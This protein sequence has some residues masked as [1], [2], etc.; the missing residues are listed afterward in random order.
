MK[1]LGNNNSAIGIIRVSS[2][3]QSDD[4]SFRENQEREI[5]E[6]CNY[7]KLN[8]R[9]VF[10]IVESAKDSDS[11]AKY[12]E[13]GRWADANKIRH[14]VF[15]MSDREARNMT[16]IEK[17]EKRILRDEIVIHHAHERKI[18]WAGAPD[19]DFF[20]REIQGVNN[21]HFSRVIRTKVNLAITRKCESGWFP[22]NRPPLGYIHEKMKDLSG[23]EMKRGTIIV[24]D[25]NEKNVR[26]IQR[27]FAMRGYENKTLSE[28]ADRLVIEGF[29]SKDK[30]KNYESSIDRRLKNKF[31]S[32]RFN[33]PS[34]GIEYEGKHELIIASDLF[35]KVQ[36]TFKGSKIFKKKRGLFSQGWLKCGECGCF[37]TYDPKT[38][39]LKSGE[40]TTALTER[41]NMRKLSMFEKILFSINLEK[42]LVAFQFLLIWLVKYV[43]KL[44]E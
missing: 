7:N 24:P 12:S 34:D 10:K 11:R 33:W 26:Q 31:Y 16:D 9:K 41:S 14:R 25:T 39:K 5:Q 38:T 43:K 21:K 28:I 37:I 35:E 1:W 27:E 8:L 23:R 2:H 32:G 13:A 22:G 40:K 3:R 17:I 18:F 29:I 30:R 19:T 44:I 42:L 36:A 4:L 6:Y 20:I 15:Y